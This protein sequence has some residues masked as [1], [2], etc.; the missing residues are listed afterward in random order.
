M[1]NEV[2]IIFHCHE[3][4]EVQHIEDAQEATEASFGEVQYEVYIFSFLMRNNN[5]WL[6]YSYR[7]FACKQ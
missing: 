7:N 1:N 5:V 2:D 4:V 3:C 6:G